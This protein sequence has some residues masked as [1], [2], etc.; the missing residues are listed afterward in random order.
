MYSGQWADPKEMEK[1]VIWVNKNKNSI[2]AY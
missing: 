1:L 2:N